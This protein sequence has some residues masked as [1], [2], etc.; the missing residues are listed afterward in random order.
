MWKYDRKG[1]LP[2]RPTPCSPRA[3]LQTFS[4]VWGGVGG[5]PLWV[6]LHV[7]YRYN[8]LNTPDVQWRN[9]FEK[10]EASAERS[11]NIEELYRGLTNESHPKSPDLT[12]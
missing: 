12:A 9:I 11:S 4:M 5:N 6:S 3:P 1:F 7:R 10:V 2:T 8:L